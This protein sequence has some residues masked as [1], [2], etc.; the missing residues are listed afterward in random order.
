MREARAPSN[1]AIPRPFPSNRASPRLSS[2]PP[3]ARPVPSAQRPACR[4]YSLVMKLMNSDAHSCTVSLESP[5]SFALLG[6]DRF[7][8]RATLAIGSTQ[9]CSRMSSA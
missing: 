9:S 3:L 4:G 1:S 5:A 7:M 2:S 6:S 8:M